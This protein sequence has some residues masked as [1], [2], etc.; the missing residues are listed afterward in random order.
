MAVVDEEKLAEP[1]TLVGNV[2]ALQAIDLLNFV[3]LNHAL[4]LAAWEVF[5][6]VA[7]L[8]LIRAA[9]LHRLL[10]A[11]CWLTFCDVTV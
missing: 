9:W 2:W 5:E 7:E 6:P 4:V 1:E 3:H 8:D 10:T 11:S